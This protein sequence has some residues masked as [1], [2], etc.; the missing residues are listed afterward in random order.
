MIRRTLYTVPAEPK[1]ART[2]FHR[3]A[4]RRGVRFLAEVG[5]Y[6]LAEENGADLAWAT[7]VAWEAYE[8]EI[9]S[10]VQG[11]KNLKQAAFDRGSKSARWIPLEGLHHRRAALIAENL[12]HGDAPPMSFRRGAPAAAD[13]PPAKLAGFF[14]LAPDRAV[15]VFDSLT[16]YPGGG[17][18]FRE[19]KVGPPSRAYLKLW[20]ICARFRHAGVAPP[21][22][23]ESAVDLGSCPGGWTWALAELGAKVFS[24]DG[25][26][27]DPG[28]AKRPEVTFQKGDAFRLEPKKVDWVFSDMICEPKRLPELIERWQA[29]GCERFA[30]SVKFKG[31]ADEAALEKL[32]AIPGSKLRHLRQNKHELTWFL[33]PGLKRI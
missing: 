21:K 27:L 5:E 2:E 25:A 30:L 24:I 17:I 11:A 22:A 18:P 4:A 13:T 3:E 19:E 28:V 20:E 16:P 10:I 29:V 14:L 33:R 1:E 31:E 9:P 8:I 26:P 32:R 12:P 6:F 23:T 15:A 7:D